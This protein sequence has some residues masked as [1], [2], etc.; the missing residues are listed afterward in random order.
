MNFQGTYVTINVPTD[1]SLDVIFIDCLISFQY[2]S[3][4]LVNW[5]AVLAP[6]GMFQFPFLLV[7]KRTNEIKMDRLLLILV[8]M[9]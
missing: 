9:D 5:V 1:P 2:H 4:H 8:I 6:L 7:E 3:L